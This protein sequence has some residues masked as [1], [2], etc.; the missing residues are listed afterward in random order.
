MKKSEVIFNIKGDCNLGKIKI[1]SFVV[2]LFL[3]PNLLFAM[4]GIKGGAPLTA[5]P[6]TPPTPQSHVQNVFSDA[7]STPITVSSWAVNS[8]AT[9]QILNNSGSNYLQYTFAA[10]KDSIQTAN[11]GP[12]NV[13]SYNYIHIDIYSPSAT[14]FSLV[15]IDG[16]SVSHQY[17]VACANPT[18]NKWVS[19]DIPLSLYSSNSVDLVN[20]NAFLFIAGNTFNAAGTTLFIDNIYFSTTANY[21][22]NSNGNLDVLSTWGTNSDGTSLGGVGNNAPSNFTSDNINY[23]V[24]NNPAATI[25]ANWKVSGNNSKVVVGDWVNPVSLTIPSTYTFTDSCMSE[26]LITPSESDVTVNVSINPAVKGL[27]IPGTFNGLSWEM[28]S[29]KSLTYFALPKFVNL[30]KNLGTGMLRI[31]A[32]TSDKLIWSHINRGTSPSTDTLFQSEVDRYF[33]FVS[34]IGWKTL[35]GLNLGTGTVAQA[36]DEAQYVS[37]NY[38]SMLQAYEIGNEPDLYPY[39]YRAK[40][41][42]WKNYVTAFDSL[43]TSINPVVSTLNIS[44]PTS[45]YNVTGFDLPF[46]NNMHSKLALAT[47][48]YYFGHSNNSD[49]KANIHSLLTIDTTLVNTITA[50]VN[51]A[52]KYNLPFRISECNS[53]NS[54]GKDSISN[55]FASALWG[56]DYMYTVAA[57]GCTG[58]NFHGGSSGFYSPTIVT[59]GNVY[60]MPLYY[61]ML[62]FSLGSKGTFIQNTT[63]KTGTV[64]CNVYTVLGTDGKYYTTIVNKDMV[65]QAFVKLTGLPSHLNTQI[66]RLNGSYIT[67][68]TCNLG[69]SSSDANG[70]W[71]NA[72]SECAGADATSY[73]LKVPKESAVVLVVN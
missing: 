27:T 16:D 10:K 14:T 68:K 33:S 47:Y 46:V 23:Y 53:F 21:F 51:T 72:S 11:F 22:S 49:G 25:G 70:N 48:H 40:N 35:F 13:A 62:A 65:N 6:P 5:M 7:Y 37:Q 71:T 39:S 38:S 52:K 3:L 29:T 58:V 34:Q 31:G 42:G 50:F 66:I 12:I 59:G 4:S 30:V 69:N 63:S 28:S 17:Q 36:T 9:A 61:G 55:A 1:A 44:G 67:N 45:G 64:N 56:T 24:V 60:P 73:Q 26:Y 43:Y 41:W 54:G 2:M 8:N 19:Y 57:L 15:L 18:L 20:L 32:G